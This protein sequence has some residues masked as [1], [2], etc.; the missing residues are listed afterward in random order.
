MGQLQKGF[1]GSSGLRQGGQLHVKW[2]STGGVGRNEDGVSGPWTNFIGPRWLVRDM[3]P[4]WLRHN[5]IG[6]QWNDQWRVNFFESNDDMC[7]LRVKIEGQTWRAW[8]VKKMIWDQ[9]PRWGLTS[10]WEEGGG[11]YGLGLK[12][13]Q[14]THHGIEKRGHTVVGGRRTAVKPSDGCKWEHTGIPQQFDH[15]HHRGTI[16]ALFGYFA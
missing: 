12:H 7:R 5:F 13:S 15:F 8:A 3:H 4:W 1:N 11:R 9:L 10:S 16:L 14:L 2:S 6:K